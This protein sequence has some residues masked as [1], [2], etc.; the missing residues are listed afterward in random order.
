MLAEERGMQAADATRPA[1][2]ASALG[3][4]YEKIGPRE[5][6]ARMQELCD[7]MLFDTLVPLRASGV[8]PGAAERFA[9]I[10]SWPTGSSRS[11]CASSPAAREAPFPASPG[12]HTLVSGVLWTMVEARLGGASRDLSALFD[13]HVH[14]DRSDG[15]VSLADRA[16]S[17]T[18]RPHGVSD[19]YPW[20]ERFRMK[21]R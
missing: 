20:R 17:V 11:R 15:T 2:R 7:G 19:H 1:K 18:V 5:F 10:S 9:C 13:H 8:G 3:F 4:L 16:K 14:S 12:G 6:F 21:T